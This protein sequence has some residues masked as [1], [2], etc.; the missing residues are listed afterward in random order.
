MIRKSLLFL[1]CLSFTEI[2]AQNLTSGPFDE[3]DLFVQPRFEYFS[4]RHSAHILDGLPY[5][6][7][8][9]SGE[10]DFQHQRMIGGL[11]GI[12]GLNFELSYLYMTSLAG[13]SNSASIRWKNG[14]IFGKETMSYTMHD[15]SIRK[16]MHARYSLG[17]RYQKLSEGMSSAQSGYRIG[18]A[19]HAWQARKLF[20]TFLSATKKVKPFL[21]DLET[22]ASLWGSLENGTSYTA[23]FLHYA[24]DLERSQ[25]A[26][27]ELPFNERPYSVYTRFGFHFSWLRVYY[28]WRMDRVKNAFTEYRNSLQIEFA[29]PFN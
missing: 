3:I 28:H 24:D 10:L 21:F 16:Q 2:H 7:E 15:F 20:Y 25:A 17:L 23:L 26:E 9:V 12:R 19:F 4:L 22:G 13:N 1:F 8:P 18:T 5:G 29:I 6:N 14:G 27:T 11:I